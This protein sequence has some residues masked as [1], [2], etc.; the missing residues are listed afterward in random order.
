MIGVKNGRLSF[1]V[2]DEKAEFHLPQAMANPTLDDTCCRV[3]VL[4]EVLNIEAM[5]PQF[6]GGSSRGRFNRLQGE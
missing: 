1:Q 5:P 6:C 2:G 4:K 3:D